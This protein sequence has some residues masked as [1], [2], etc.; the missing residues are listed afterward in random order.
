MGCIK[1]LQAKEVENVY[2]HIRNTM[3]DDNG[4]FRHIFEQAERMARHIGE[5]PGKSRNTSRQQH[6][7]NAGGTEDSPF[8]YYKKIWQYHWLITSLLK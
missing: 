6:R 2:K 1:Y 4:Q 7:N 5:E 8:M 3:D